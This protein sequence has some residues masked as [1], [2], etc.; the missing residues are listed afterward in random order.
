[1]QFVDGPTLQQLLSAS[2]PIQG[3]AAA[4]LFVQVANAL[5]AAH[6]RSIVHRDVKPSNILI[7]QGSNCAKVTDFGLALSPGSTGRTWQNILPGTPE[8]M[9]PEQLTSDAP[10]DSR[11]DIYSLGVALYHALTGS[12]PFDGP[13]SPVIKR[14]LGEEPWPP[15]KLNPK[16][17]NDLE[18]VCLK[19]MR[20]SPADRYQTAIALRDDLRRFLRSEP[21]HARRVSRLRRTASWFRRRP[22]R[23]AAAVLLL[24]CLAGAV[25]VNQWNR[26]QT[27]SHQ[28]QLN[29]AEQE[30][31]DRASQLSVA[32]Q[33]T[34]QLQDQA[35]ELRDETL[36]LRDEVEQK[37]AEKLQPVMELILRQQSVPDNSARGVMGMILSSLRPGLKQQID[38]M[39]ARDDPSEAYQLA[40]Y[41]RRY[42]DLARKT[43][44]DP[45]ALESLRVADEL[46]TRVDPATAD[47]SHEELLKQLANCKRDLGWLLTQAGRAGE[48]VEIHREAEW[49]YAE[50]LENKLGAVHL[51]LERLRNQIGLTAAALQSAGEISSTENLTQRLEEIERTAQQTRK[52]WLVN[53]E[54]IVRTYHEFAEAAAG[55]GH[56]DLAEGALHKSY[57]F[58]R[59]SL[60]NNQAAGNRNQ[61][62]TMFHQLAERLYANRQQRLAQVTL[63]LAIRL[64]EECRAALPAAA[65]T[66]RQPYDQLIEEAKLQLEEIKAAAQ[67]R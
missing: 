41:R 51:K 65:N 15:R 18:T 31:Q 24:C 10:T 63:E 23:V 11:S 9:S 54:P 30:L 17:H 49:L 39:E 44:D 13:A 20:K 61:L 12:T 3:R 26:V 47:C 7:E 62:G 27:R 57:D 6:D 1:M 8:Y 56:A 40:L 2:G 21:I 67:E 19:A 29:Q 33:T 60:Q 66:E 64:Y 55:C 4:E 48:A 50:L 34:S 36:E 59:L 42:A 52:I 22:E 5:S 25:A 53:S 43:N 58:T 14:I 16:I 38:R 37:E 35:D 46:F 45:A 28:A 32:Q